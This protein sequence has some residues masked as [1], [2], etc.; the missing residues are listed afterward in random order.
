NAMVIDARG[1]Q[2]HFGGRLPASGG[3]SF[4]PAAALHEPIERLGRAG[5][6]SEIRPV[7]PVMLFQQVDQAPFDRARFVVARVSSEIMLEQMLRAARIADVRTIDPM[8]GE[9]LKA[10]SVGESA[11]EADFVNATGL[12]KSSVNV[13]DYEFHSPL[14]LPQVSVKSDLAAH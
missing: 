7:K 1:A 2:L 13:E 8:I 14:R 10:V 9:N 11:S 3:D 4:R 5:N 12:R 6:L